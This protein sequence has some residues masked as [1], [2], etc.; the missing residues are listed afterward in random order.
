MQVFAVT[1]LAT[2]RRIFV[3][4]ASR[5]EFGLPNSGLPDSTAFDFGVVADASWSTCLGARLAPS[6]VRRELFALLPA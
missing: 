2:R 5:L 6:V 4:F 1:F 3:A